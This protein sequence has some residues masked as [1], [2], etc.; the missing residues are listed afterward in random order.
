MGE[1]ASQFKSLS[2]KVPETERTVSELEQKL[3]ELRE[4]QESIEKELASKQDVRSATAA[5]VEDGEYLT[6]GQGSRSASGVVNELESTSLGSN[7]ATRS[8]VDIAN[9]IEMLDVKRE[10]AD[11]EK[12]ILVKRKERHETELLTLERTARDLAK[13]SSSSNHEEIGERN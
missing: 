13:N 12:S 11:R 6:H 9:D 1:V 8:A 2:E 4:K 5:L 10:A 3:K 7:G